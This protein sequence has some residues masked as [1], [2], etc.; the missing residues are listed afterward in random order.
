MGLQYCS[1]SHHWH[2]SQFCIYP[3]SGDSDSDASD[4]VAAQP[5]G[6]EDKLDA[7]SPAGEGGG[8]AVCPLILHGDPLTDR[9]STFQAHGA[10]VKK[11]EQVSQPILCT[12]S[13]ESLLMHQALIVH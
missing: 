8:T 3:G 6:E 11:T 13:F 10:E 9:K 12:L 5:R 2:C 4:N 7:A 1:Y